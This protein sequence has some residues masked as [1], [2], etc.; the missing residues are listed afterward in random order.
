MCADLGTTFSLD[1]QRSPRVSRGVKL[2]V[3][4]AHERTRQRSTLKLREWQRS[5]AFYAREALDARATAPC[6][7]SHPHRHLRFMMIDIVFPASIPATSLRDIGSIM[8][9]PSKTSSMPCGA[10]GANL[11]R[12][13]MGVPRP[14]LAGEGRVR[15]YARTSTGASAPISSRSHSSLILALTNSTVSPTA[16]CVGRGGMG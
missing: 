7:V 5:S 11:S 12:A 4:G 10:G 14:P 1:N 9:V 15:P 8:A 13:G 6:R 3:E 16:N 2:Y